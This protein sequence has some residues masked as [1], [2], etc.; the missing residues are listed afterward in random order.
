MKSQMLTELDTYA[1]EIPE[2]VD[3]PYELIKNDDEKIDLLS[4]YAAVTVTHNT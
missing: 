2:C 1:E 3:D 4:K